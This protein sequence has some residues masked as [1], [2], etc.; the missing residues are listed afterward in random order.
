MAKRG[1]IDSSKN[2]AVVNVGNLTFH[3]LKDTFI[4]SRFTDKMKDKITRIKAYGEEYFKLIED[5]PD[6]QKIF[7]LGEKIIFLLD[8]KVYEVF[9]EDK[10]KKEK[11]K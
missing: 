6:L 7:A 1:K 10:E 9:T 3:K 11:S 4:D 2:T 8:D 5:H